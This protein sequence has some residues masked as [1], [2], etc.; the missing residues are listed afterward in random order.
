M[1][2]TNGVQRVLS[3]QCQYGQEIGE[4]D[5]VKKPTGWLSNSPKILKRLQ[6]RCRGRAGKCTWPGRGDHVTASGKVAREAAAYP[7]NVCRDILKGCVRQLWADGGLQLGM[8]G[9]QGLWEEAAAK[10]WQ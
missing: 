1:L 4:G 6:K 3:D 10:S 2:K 5:P 8:R 7:A 9:A